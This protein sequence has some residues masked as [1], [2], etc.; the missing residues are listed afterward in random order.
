[1]SKPTLS[2]HDATLQMGAGFSTHGS[3]HKDFGGFSAHRRPRTG[4]LKSPGRESS[5]SGWGEQSSV[6][7]Q[8]PSPASTTRSGS[9]AAVERSCRR[10]SRRSGALSTAASSVVV[11]REVQ[12]AVREALGIY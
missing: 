7:D 9:R 4:A 1:M 8:P 5:R 2:N 10:T 11:K 12:K 3:A 6:W